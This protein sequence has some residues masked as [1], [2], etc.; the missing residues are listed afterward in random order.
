MITVQGSMIRTAIE[1]ANPARLDEVTDAVEQVMLARFGL[2][3]IVGATNAVI[4][5]VEKPSA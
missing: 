3:P 1:A 5:T 2:G 4:V